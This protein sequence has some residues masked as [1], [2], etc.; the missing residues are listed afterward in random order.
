MKKNETTIACLIGAIGFMPS[1]VFLTYFSY[2]LEGMRH[3]LFL[4]Y[5]TIMAS[6][7]LLSVYIYRKIRESKKEK[8]LQDALRNSNISQIDT[9]SPFEFEEWVAR[10]LRTM[11]YKAY[12]TKKSGDYGVDVIAENDNTKIAVQVKK[13]NKSVGIKAVQEVI[14]GMSYYNCYE[15]WV[16]TSANDF[17]PA[18]RNLASKQD[19]KLITRN[20][21]AILLNNKNVV[22]CELSKQQS[23]ISNEKTES[24]TTLIIDKRPNQNINLIKPKLLKYNNKDYCNIKKYCNTFTYEV[25]D[26]MLMKFKNDNCFKY[27]ID[28]MPYISE[29]IN[30]GNSF[31]KRLFNLLEEESEKSIIYNLEYVKLQGIFYIGMG[32]IWLWG[33]ADNFNANDTLDILLKKNGL[34]YLDETV[35][36]KFKIAIDSKEWID[37]Y[38]KL[39]SYQIDLLNDFDIAYI[40]HDNDLDNYYNCMQAMFILG[41]LFAIQKLDY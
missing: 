10:L 19:I 29:F 25:I 21:L 31:S 17:T 23:K 30:Y 5:L 18:A 20:D 26:Y 4:G 1:G 6:V 41:M 13:F 24:K 14:A 27:K 12:T 40:F 11:D 39:N 34:I 8:E 36:N 33:T 7:V 2:K 3:M 37:F 16:I 15:G 22:N 35:L 28:N 38:K 9:L 32:I